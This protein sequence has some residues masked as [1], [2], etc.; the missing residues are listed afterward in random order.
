MLVHDPDRINDYTHVILDEVHERD[1]D[2]DFVSLV[3]KL[4]LF[5]EEQATGKRKAHFRLV[6]MSATIQGE[7]FSRYFGSPRDIDEVDVDSLQT[8]DLLET[9]EV[10]AKRFQVGVLHLEDLLT[11]VRAGQLDTLPLPDRNWTAL[12]MEPQPGNFRRL[13]GSAEDRPQVSS[14]ALSALYRRVSQNLKLT[15]W[16]ERVTQS[17][18]NRDAEDGLVDSSD[19]RQDRPS[20]SA[21][22]ATS[23]AGAAAPQ[24][25]GNYSGKGAGKAFARR[26]PG[27]PAFSRARA[28][29]ARGLD[30]VTADVLKAV[31]RPGEGVLIFLPGINDLYD[32]H[33]YRKFSRGALPCRITF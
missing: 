26:I 23:D 25:K 13:P 11:P 24:S 9:I 33:E 7:L 1:L 5:E 8:G 17:I 27:Q 3:V 32:L 30:G 18:C 12:R 19:S 10:G 21:S 31:A 29:V 20:S 15:S 2:Q 22:S 6:V 4:K 14:A 28:E 16:S